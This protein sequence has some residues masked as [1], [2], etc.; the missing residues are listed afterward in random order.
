MWFQSVFTPT[1]SLL[2]LFQY[3]IYVILDYLDTHTYIY[4][5]ILQIGRKNSVYDDIIFMY[6][7]VT[8]S[9]SKYKRK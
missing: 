7:F 9:R 3:L 2:L 6:L 4:I 1:E 5:Y 8:I